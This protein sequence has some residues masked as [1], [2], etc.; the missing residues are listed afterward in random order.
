MDIAGGV[1]ADCSAPGVGG[2]SGGGDGG[3]NQQPNPQRRIY[4]TK[5]NE[6]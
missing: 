6:D 1:D 5:Q 4:K 2:G 3:G